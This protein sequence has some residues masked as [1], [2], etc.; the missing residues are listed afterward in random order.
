ME[1]RCGWKGK[2]SVGG[3]ACWM[4]V[5]IAPDPQLYLAPFCHVPLPLVRSERCYQ[6]IGVLVANHSQLH[7]PGVKVNP[8]AA[9]SGSSGIGGAVAS[10]SG[11][12]A[13]PQQVYIPGRTFSAGVPFSPGLQPTG[14][15]EEE[16]PRAPDASVHH[17]G[18][19]AADLMRSQGAISAPSGK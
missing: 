11:S 18:S 10:G 1:G 7:P 14:E 4:D 2:S 15:D 13:H 5:A 16:G 6:D 9:G 17:G 19:A 8:L 12:G 3:L